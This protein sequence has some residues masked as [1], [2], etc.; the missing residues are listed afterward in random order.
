LISFIQKLVLLDNFFKL[1]DINICVTK[2]YY[3]VIAEFDVFIQK[4][5]IPIND[6]KQKI[7]LIKL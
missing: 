5:L 6:H 4:P 2:H 1:L 7:E 3:Q